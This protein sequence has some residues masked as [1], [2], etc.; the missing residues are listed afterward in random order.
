MLES[1][2]SDEEEAQRPEEPCDPEEP[3]MDG[4]DDEFSDIEWDEDV[5]HSI[6]TVTI[7]HSSE[8]PY[9]ASTS[10]TPRYL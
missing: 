9:Y 3:V 8:A 4:S 10:P 2:F 6:E 7:S 5:S 1:V